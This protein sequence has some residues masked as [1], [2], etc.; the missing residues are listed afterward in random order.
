M[1]AMVENPSS[2]G[3]DHENT[4]RTKSRVGF[5]GAPSGAWASRRSD[6]RASPGTCLDIGDAQL[7]AVMRRECPKLQDG[8]LLLQHRIFLD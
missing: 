1:S 2:L 8:Y 5:I 4:K 3:L 6:G 7:A